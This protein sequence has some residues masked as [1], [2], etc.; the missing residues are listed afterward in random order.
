MGDPAQRVKELE[1]QNAKLQKKLAKAE[2]QRDTVA[3]YLVRGM[4]AFGH[5]S[6]RPAAGLPLLPSA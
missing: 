5:A 3:E 1:A 4:H 6:C 2:A